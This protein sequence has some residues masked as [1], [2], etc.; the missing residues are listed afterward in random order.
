MN[1]DEREET[2]D[3]TRE[4]RRTTLY[5]LYLRTPIREVDADIAAMKTSLFQRDMDAARTKK[6][7][8]LDVRDS[9]R[10]QCALLL[11]HGYAEER[12][13]SRADFT[14]Q[15]AA[16]A[17][18]AEN[19]ATSSPYHFS[20]FVVVPHACARIGNQLARI[21]AQQFLRDE[22]FSYEP[23]L[24][25]PSHPYLITDV[26]AGFELRNVS[27]EDA[28]ALLKQQG[29]SPL[30]LE[31]VIACV[32]QTAAPSSTILD[33]TFPVSA[34]TRHSSVY[35]PDLYLSGKEPASGKSVKLKRETLQHVYAPAWS[36]PSCAGR[37]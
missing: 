16:L 3:G 9:W 14:L 17:P 30:T 7:R 21:H 6:T 10:H 13:I 23:S 26:S 36:I 35:V 25:I 34:G 27:A 19:S 2:C 1:T 18:A 20:Y 11:N 4:A 22:E 28:L 32:L 12:H 24:V 31:E 37:F 5:S 8:L 33:Y 29:R 15:L